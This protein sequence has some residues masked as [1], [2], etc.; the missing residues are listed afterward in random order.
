[1]KDH[2]DGWGAHHELGDTALSWSAWKREGKKSCLTAFLYFVKG[3][4]R[5][6]EMD[7][8]QRCKD[9]RLWSQDVVREASLRYR[10]K[11]LS[12]SVIQHYARLSQHVT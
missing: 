2:C 1:V 5:K 7:V 9:K 3:A 8:F 6:R 11:I 4:H 12:M 10:G